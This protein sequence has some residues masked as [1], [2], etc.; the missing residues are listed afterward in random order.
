MPGSAMSEQAPK[1]LFFTGVSAN[2][3]LLRYIFIALMTQATLTK[4][5]ISQKQLV[6]YYEGSKRHGDKCKHC[7]KPGHW[8]DECPNP[9]PFKPSA[10]KSQMCQ[11]IGRP[12]AQPSEVRKY[13][14]TYLS[15]FRRSHILSRH[16]APRRTD[17]PNSRKLGWGKE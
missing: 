16:E 3:F 2:H 9:D 6:A 1:D 15:L 5:P 7:K 10:T 17:H 4:L 13:F 14:S 8:G 12:P 11:M